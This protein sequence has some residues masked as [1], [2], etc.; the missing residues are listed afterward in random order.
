MPIC[1]SNAKFKIRFCDSYVF[2][3]YDL[4]R[5]SDQ[6]YDSDVWVIV[7]IHP[8]SYQQL[9]SDTNSSA[10]PCLII[11]TGLQAGGGGLN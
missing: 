3:P 8:S 4:E 5:G 9:D 11:G 10:L 7:Q 1:T 6:I 2:K